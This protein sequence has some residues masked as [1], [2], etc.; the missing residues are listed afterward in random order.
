MSIKISLLTEQQVKS[1]SGQL[2]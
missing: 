2:H 1:I